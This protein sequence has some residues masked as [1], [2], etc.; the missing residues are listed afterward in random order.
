MFRSAHGLMENACFKNHW[1]QNN[2]LMFHKMLNSNTAVS[3][4]LPSKYL[5]LTINAHFKNLP[6]EV[7][8]SITVQFK[9][10]FNEYS[11]HTPSLSLSFSIF[12]QHFTYPSMIVLNAICHMLE[13]SH[14][15]NPQSTWPSSCISNKSLLT[16]H[17]WF[18]KVCLNRNV[19]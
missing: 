19:S 18:L 14:F 6:I 1:I 9:S 11:F 3:K 17:Q 15:F 8:N 5:A 12:P 16:F 4:K 13:C 7:I 2:R 10:Q